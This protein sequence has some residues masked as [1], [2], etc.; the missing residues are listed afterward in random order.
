MPSENLDQLARHRGDAVDNRPEVGAAGNDI[1]ELHLPRCRCRWVNE[2]R[3]GSP[4]QLEYL[5][6]CRCRHHELAIRRQ[7]ILFLEPLD[8]IGAGG[9]G[10]DAFSLLQPVA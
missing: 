4:Q 6:P 9:G 1:V 10:A 2:A 5:Q 8:D 3:R 7:Q